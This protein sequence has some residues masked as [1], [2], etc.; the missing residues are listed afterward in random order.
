MNINNL[1]KGQIIRNYKELC[2]LLDIKVEAGNSKK[3][4]LKELERFVKYH[5]EG[6]KFIID[7]IYS[8]V[9]DKVDLRNEG[10]SSIYG[11]NIK[12]LLL[13]LMATSVENDEIILPIS[14]LLNKLSMVNVNYS[15]G[16][17]NQD[18]LSE[19]LNIDEKYISEFYDTTHQNLK[20]T[21]ETNL[22]QLDRKAILRWETVR[23]ICKKVAIVKYNELDEIEIDT[24]K[25]QYNIK[26]EYSVATK[27]Q[28]LLILEAENEILK[29]LKLEDINDVFRCGKADVFYKKVYTILRKKANIKYYF[30]GYKLIYN[31]DIVIDEL[32]KYG[33]DMCNVRHELNNIVKEKIFDNAIKRQ[34]KIINEFKNVMG[35][36]PSNIKDYKRMRLSEEYLNIM[37]L[38]ID[39][40]INLTAK[41]IRHKLKVEQKV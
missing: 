22:N 25:V 23:M 28:D 41:D 3:A 2:L 31:R 21:L 7:E 4:Q 20:R 10:N 16:R 18:K 12:R 35:E 39:N 37:Q 11:D 30:N 38:L 5:K 33:E 36:L 13:L 17:R 1:G 14:I 27:E 15:L 34:E 6:N 9:K 29:E 8:I 19:V 24:N 32:E 26:E 40:I